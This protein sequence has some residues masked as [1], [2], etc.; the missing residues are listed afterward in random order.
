MTI[1][2]HTHYIPKS[3]LAMLRARDKPPFVDHAD[4]RD[5]FHLPVGEVV[6]TP[7]YM[8]MADRIRFMDE[9]GVDAQLLSFAGLFGADSLPVAEALPILQAFNDH[10]AELCKT[11]PDRLGALAGIPFADMD[12]ARAEY[13]RARIDLGLIGVVL[14]INYFLS[15][16]FAE[17]MRPVFDVVK[18]LGGYV[19]LHPGPRPDQ[20]PDL[21]AGAPPAYGDN[22]MHRNTLDVQ[23]R[24]GHAMLT[25]LM[26]DFLDDYA[27]VPIHVA[28]LGGTLPAVVERL[29]NL[30]MERTPD[31]PLPSTQLRKVHID[32][33][34]FGPHTLE[35]AA[36]FFGADLIL[37]GTDCPIFRT[38]RSLAAIEAA[39]LTAAE[40]D[41]V[42][43]GNAARLLADLWPL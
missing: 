27:D 42:R 10:A 22:L 18:E 15:R 3:V 2:V 32:C 17:Q 12:A 4:G 7:D 19:F 9:V 41:G 16:E 29:D 26:T 31:A 30:S 43:H 1:D 35:L 13:R 14:P 6:L 8:D 36:H 5:W 34:S 25:L 28:N 37:L 40:K 23:S 20:R 11:H 38:D 21:A 39:D 24:V 33:S